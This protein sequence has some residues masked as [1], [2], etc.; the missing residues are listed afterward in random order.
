MFYPCEELFITALCICLWNLTWSLCGWQG[1]I[2]KLNETYQKLKFDWN[3][4]FSPNTEG[5]RAHPWTQPYKL[6]TM[7]MASA[8]KTEFTQAQCYLT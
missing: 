6:T 4:T 7:H 2:Q 1:G 3:P 5:L 8:L